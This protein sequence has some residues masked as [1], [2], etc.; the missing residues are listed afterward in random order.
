MFP[1]LKIGLTTVYFNPSGK[2]PVTRTALQL[3][4]NGAIVNGA[5]SFIMRLQISSYPHVF[6]ALNDLI[7]FS[8]PYIS[9]G[10][11]P[12]DFWKGS[13]KVVYYS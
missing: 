5:V 7:I 12:T 2:T 8:I 3:Y 10:I 6:I 9:R 11:L 13:S 1:F 4:V